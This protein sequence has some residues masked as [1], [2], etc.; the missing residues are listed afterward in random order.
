MAYVLLGDA[1]MSIQEVCKR[2]AFENFKLR[3]E[4]TMG[5][6][7]SSSEQ[8]F[9]KISGCEIFTAFSVLSKNILPLKSLRQL[10]SLQ[11]PNASLMK[12]WFSRTIFHMM[13]IVL[14]SCISSWVDKKGCSLSLQER[15]RYTN[16]H[17]R[18]IQ[19]TTPLL[20]RLVRPMCSVTFIQRQHLIDFYWRF[21]IA[22]SSLL[23]VL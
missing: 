7:R 8:M 17:W 16:R 9:W 1:Y 5:L 22:F 13:Q 20:K 18:T 6:L 23:I 12:T 19:K 10:Y 15:S 4:P 3:F 2:S 21:P 14:F 11:R